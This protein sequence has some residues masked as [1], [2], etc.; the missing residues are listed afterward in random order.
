MNVYKKEYVPIAKNSMTGTVVELAFLEE[1]RRER[2]LPWNQV[3]EAGG[4]V[5]VLG[6]EVVLTL[7]IS[8]SEQP[9]H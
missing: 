4:M 1:G 7:K 5:S 9:C 6:G 3:L 2:D 8:Q